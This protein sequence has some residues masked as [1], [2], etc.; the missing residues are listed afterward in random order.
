MSNRALRKVH[1]TKDD[2]SSLASILQL[3]EENEETD[4]FNV[5]RQ[6][7]KKATNLFDLVC[8]N[9]LTN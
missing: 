4:T 9:S 5:E 8:L 2:I 1:G 6:R 7:K 3:D